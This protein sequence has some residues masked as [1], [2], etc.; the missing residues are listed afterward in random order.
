MLFCDAITDPTGE[1][2]VGQIMEKT[3][4]GHTDKDLIRIEKVRPRCMMMWPYECLLA[5]ER[6]HQVLENL[7]DSEER[8]LNLTATQS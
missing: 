4:Q 2:D 6:C 8:A 3:F 7:L 1:F 5:S